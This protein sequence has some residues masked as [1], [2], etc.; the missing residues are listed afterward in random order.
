M[1]CFTSTR[2]NADAKAQLGELFHHLRHGGHTLF[3]RKGFLQDT[4]ALGG[5][6]LGAIARDITWQG[7]SSHGGRALVA[8]HGSSPIVLHSWRAGAFHT[9][10]SMIAL[11]GLCASVPMPYSSARH[12]NK[13]AQ[14]PQRPNTGLACGRLCMLTR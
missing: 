11:F 1:G 4:N 12:S 3:Q 5:T 8:G 10:C 9:G 13:V 14:I 2:F 7:T 6:G